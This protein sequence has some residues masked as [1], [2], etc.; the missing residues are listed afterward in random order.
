MKNTKKKLLLD[1]DDI[2]FDDKE[3]PKSELIIHFTDVL[4]EIVEDNCINAAE[5]PQLW[6]LIYFIGNNIDDESL[7]F[8]IISPENQI[9]ASNGLKY[10]KECICYLVLLFYDVSIHL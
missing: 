9:H 4:C 3:T 6:Y 2:K 1:L 5:N 10:L 7:K 8:T